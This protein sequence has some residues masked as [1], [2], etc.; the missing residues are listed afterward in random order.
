MTST[1]ILQGEGDKVIR[2]LPSMSERRIYELFATE[3]ISERYYQDALRK[4]LNDLQL[5]QIDGKDLRH[6]EDELD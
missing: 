2:K 1:Q 4:S 3:E 6:N 5:A